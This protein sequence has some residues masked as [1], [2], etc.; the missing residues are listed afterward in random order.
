MIDT[1]CLLFDLAVNGFCEC[2][3]ECKCVRLY[4]SGPRPNRD[5]LSNVWLMLIDNNW[6]LIVV[7]VNC[8]G[9]ACSVTQHVAHCSLSVLRIQIKW[10]VEHWC[11]CKSQ[12]IHKPRRKKKRISMQFVHRVLVDRLFFFDLSSVVFL[13]MRM[14]IET[15][16]CL[17]NMPPILSQCGIVV[18]TRK[19]STFGILVAQ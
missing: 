17:L 8:C 9:A 5:P 7:H 12:M 10:L 19:L 16:N 15:K 13:E 6:L 2:K 3:L 11:K 18:W 1:C 14:A 4:E